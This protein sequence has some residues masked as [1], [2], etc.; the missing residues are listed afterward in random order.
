MLYCNYIHK[1]TLFLAPHQATGTYKEMTPWISKKSVP[2]VGQRTK[3]NMAFKYENRPLV[4]VYYDVN[5]SHQY[6]KGE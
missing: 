2:L 3:D 4:V 1:L 6:I 5:F